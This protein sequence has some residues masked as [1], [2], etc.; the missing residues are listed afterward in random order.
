MYTISGDKLGRMWTYAEI[1]A[2]FI[3]IT[4]HIFIWSKDKHFQVNNKT[5]LSYLA[6][7]WVEVL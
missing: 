6:E 5:K 1:N 2:L 3:Y 4:P 7:H